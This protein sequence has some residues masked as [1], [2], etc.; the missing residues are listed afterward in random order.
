[1]INSIARQI[2]IAFISILL[3]YGVLAAFFIFLKP[4]QS[5]TGV[6]SLISTT[7]IVFGTWFIA[8][9]IMI[10]IAICVIAAIEELFHFIKKN[11]QQDD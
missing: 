9:A 2:T 3:C 7:F 6:T 8:I 10:L 4:P 1:M 5:T 11:A